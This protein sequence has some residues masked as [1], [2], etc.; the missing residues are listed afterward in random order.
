MDGWGRRAAGC[1]IL[2]MTVLKLN[3]SN[4]ATIA[5]NREV[6]KRAG[7]LSVPV[8][9]IDTQQEPGSREKC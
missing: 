7:A 2:K 8:E 6:Q 4:S 9:M 1:E 5:V 3:I